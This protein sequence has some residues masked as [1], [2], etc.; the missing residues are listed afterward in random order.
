MLIGNPPP[1]ESRQMLSPG[2]ATPAPAPEPDIK[3]LIGEAMAAAACIMAQALG[4]YWDGGL[5][6]KTKTASGDL[7]A[8]LYELRQ[9]TMGEFDFE[10]VALEYGWQTL[11]ARCNGGG[12]PTKTGDILLEETLSILR[13]VTAT[14]AAQL[15]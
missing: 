2:P 9:S 14:M 7:I 11:R 13:K 6:P 1:A 4:E 3:V 10:Q 8:Q 12:Y 15:N 5:T